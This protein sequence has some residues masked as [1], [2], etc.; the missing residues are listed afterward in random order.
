[1]DA[2]TTILTQ[3]NDYLASPDFPQKK[4]SLVD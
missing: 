1:M 2:V 4:Y 3:A